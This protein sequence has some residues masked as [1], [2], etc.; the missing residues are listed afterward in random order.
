MEDIYEDGHLY[1]TFDDATLTVTTYDKKGNVVGT[2]P[3]TEAEI[4][5]SQHEDTHDRIKAIVDDLQA[6]KDR[7]Q[8]MIDMSNADVNANPAGPIKDSARAGKRIAD[9]CIDLAKFVD[10]K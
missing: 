9:A 8:L 5:Q 10:G 4:A 7:L 3:Y 6:E 2:R 1:E